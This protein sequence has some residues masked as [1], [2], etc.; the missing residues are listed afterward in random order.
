VLQGTLDTLSLPELFDVLAATKKTGALHVR[1][2]R[3]LG[4]VYFDGGSVCAAEAG[5]QSGPV[6]DEPAVISRLHDVC[7]EL[8]RYETGSFEFEPGGPPRWPVL[9]S[10]PVDVL[11]DEAGRRLTE[12]KDI[13]AVVPSV[14]CRPWL[15][16]DP[17]GKQVVLEHAQWRM[18]TAIAGRRRVSAI[19]RLLE[20]SEFDVCRTLKSLVDVGLVEI[21]MPSAIG[22]E[23]AIEADGAETE[24]APAPTARRSRSRKEAASADTGPSDSGSDPE[25]SGNGT[26][27]AAAELHELAEAEVADGEVTDDDAS[28]NDPE[29]KEAL[30]KFLSSVRDA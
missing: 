26:M 18:V 28:E 4:V 24:S 30:V 19:M 2:T 21:E 8:F 12:W 6:E 22:S 25:L 13:E 16:A 20:V 29:F 15:V 11:V 27:D 7:F 3:G 1:G 10:V 9:S 23:S 5:V 17:P 14:E